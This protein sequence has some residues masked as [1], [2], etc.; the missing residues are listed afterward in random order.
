M[1]GNAKAELALTSWLV[2][3][4]IEGRSGF[5]FD[6]ERN[7]IRGQ[8]TVE[9]ADIF[10]FVPRK[11]VNDPRRLP[12]FIGVPSGLKSMFADVDWKDVIV[13]EDVIVLV[14]KV[15][16]N[17]EGSPKI[18]FELGIPISQ[19]ILDA[20]KRG[21]AEVQERLSKVGDT[22]GIE[23]DFCLYDNDTMN[24]R[25]ILVSSL[26]PVKSVVFKLVYRPCFKKGE[27]AE[28]SHKRKIG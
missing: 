24:E 8:L 3:T 17:K 23:V 2:E 25:Q 11:R 9:G 19:N 12:F 15:A 28:L 7:K 20:I 18:G 13:Y 22:E 26:R 21:H 16:L 10:R 14:T 27:M 1:K 6:E 5:T 4:S